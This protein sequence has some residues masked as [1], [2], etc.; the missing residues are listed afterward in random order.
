[1]LPNVKILYVLNVKN[2]NK[3][4]D[5]KHEYYFVDSK[6]KSN[7]FSHFPQYS[8]N[9]GINLLPY[10]NGFYEKGL[11]MFINNSIFILL[12]EYLKVLLLRPSLMMPY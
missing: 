6:R 11:I 7:S 8:H 12:N 4:C 1:M 3:A 9:D 2:L 5:I 10:L